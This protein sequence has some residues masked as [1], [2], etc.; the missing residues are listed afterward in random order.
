MRTATAYTKTWRP[1][2]EWSWRSLVRVRRVREVRGVRRVRVRRVRVR[3]VRAKAACLA[4][5][6]PFA[7]PAPFAPTSHPKRRQRQP[8]EAMVQRGLIEIRAAEILDC[9]E[10]KRRHQL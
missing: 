3:R 9:D 8:L 6:A 5:N 1:L 10:R 2:Q 7:P 4:P